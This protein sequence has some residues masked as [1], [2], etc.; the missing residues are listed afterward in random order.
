MR[1]ISH[2]RTVQAIA[3]VNRRRRRLLTL[4]AQTMSC[5]NRPHAVAFTHTDTRARQIHYS[6]TEHTRVCT[7]LW[8]IY[9]CSLGRT[10]SCAEAFSRRRVPGAPAST[11]VIRTRKRVR[12]TKRKVHREQKRL[13]KDCGLERNARLFSVS[14]ADIGA[15]E[16][17]LKASLFAH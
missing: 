3:A 12:R 1:R 16:C 10:R 11:R 6:H 14:T 17:S 9:K 15:P 4:V 7:H 2:H 13:W 8:N 5:G